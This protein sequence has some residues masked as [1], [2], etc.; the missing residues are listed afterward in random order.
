MNGFKLK[1]YTNLYKNGKDVDIEK[2]KKKEKKEKIEKEDIYNHVY[3]NKM[4]VKKKVEE[5]K[6]VFHPF[7]ADD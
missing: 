4:N 7:L 1:A 2:L 5:N 3:F 6:R